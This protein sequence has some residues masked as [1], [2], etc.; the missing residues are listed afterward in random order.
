M[1]AERA[2]KNRAKK[3]TQEDSSCMFGDRTERHTNSYVLFL[4]KVIWVFTIIINY[5]TI[6]EVK[7]KL[8]NLKKL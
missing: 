4:Y 3:Q 1:P 8:N 7:K 5:L 6:A 2:P